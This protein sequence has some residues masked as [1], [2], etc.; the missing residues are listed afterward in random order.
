MEK[1]TDIEKYNELLCRIPLF[2]DLPQNVKATL[3]GGGLSGVPCQ[4]ERGS[5]PTRDDCSPSVCP[6]AGEIKSRYH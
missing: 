1:L 2:C 4:Q 3:L 6:V 5:C